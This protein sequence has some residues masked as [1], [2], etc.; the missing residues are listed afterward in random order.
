MLEAKEGNPELW[1]VYRFQTAV[2]REPEADWDQ[3]KQSHPN[4]EGVTFLARGLTFAQAVQMCKLAHEE[5]E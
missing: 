4:E 2:W 1:V 5:D 3:Y